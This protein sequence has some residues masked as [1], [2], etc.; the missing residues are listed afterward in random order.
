MSFIELVAQRRPPQPPKGVSPPEN[1]RD[2][3]R[4]TN[5]ATEDDTAEVLVFDSIGGWF[6]LYADEFVDQLNQITASNI[7]LRLNSPGG[8]VFEGIAI[9]NAIRHHPAN[10]TV[11]VDSLAASIASVIMLAGDKVVMMPGAQTMIHAASTVCYGNAAEMIE[12]AELLQKQTVNIA[13]AYQGRAG[14]TVDEWLARMDAETWL[15]AEET[16]ALGLADEIYMPPKKEEQPACPPAEAVMNRTWDLSMYQY[17]GREQ[18]PAPRLTGPVLATRR[19]SAGD[20]NALE[21]APSALLNGIAD[22]AVP[23]AAKEAPGTVTVDFSSWAAADQTFLDTLRD[24][25]RQELKAGGEVPATETPQPDDSPAAET[26]T[27]PDDSFPPPDEE[28]EEDDEDAPPDEED[29]PADKADDW[30]SVVGLL[31]SPT[32]SPSADDVFAHIQEGW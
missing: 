9:A 23:A 5:S 20:L 17:A 32:T 3:F 6:G 18:A 22:A 7:K 31:V 1:A 11:Y 28:E 30:T 27:P 4:I 14:G 8:S 13:M 12:T 15:N 10:V 21:T 2:W 16:V 24:L 19:F 29:G 26:P 25:I